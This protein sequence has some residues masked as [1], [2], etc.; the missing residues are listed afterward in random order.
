MFFKPITVTAVIFFISLF[1]SEKQ[2]ACIPDDV[3]DAVMNSPVVN[4]NF[5]KNQLTAV[6]PR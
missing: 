3:F 2:A 6:P 5:S 4:V 1:L